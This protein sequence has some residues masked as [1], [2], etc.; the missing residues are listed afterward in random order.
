MP[1]TESHGNDAGGN[2]A[3]FIG[4]G[5]TFILILGVLA[6]GGFFLD[7]LLGTLPL[8]LF[9]GLGVGFA[10]A[11]YYVYLALKKLGDG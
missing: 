5:F 6:T 10:G 9:V 7:R 3:R 11:L 2:Y 8:F 4:L 1:G